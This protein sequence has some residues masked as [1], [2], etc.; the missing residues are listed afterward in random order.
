MQISVVNKDY[1]GNCGHPK[2]VHVGACIGRNQD[3][4]KCHCYHFIADCH[5]RDPRDC[6]QKA[7]GECDICTDE[8]IDYLEREE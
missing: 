2:I 3:G 4:G 7:N 1:C 6:Q 5:D 8:F